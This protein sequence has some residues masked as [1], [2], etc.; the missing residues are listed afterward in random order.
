MLDQDNCVGLRIYYA[1]DG[2]GEKHVVISGVTANE[3][4]LYQG[5][6]AE[7]ALR[8]PPNGGATNP[9]NS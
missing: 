9:L 5:I 8:N 1:L 3:D 7:K 2:N 6:L 4:D